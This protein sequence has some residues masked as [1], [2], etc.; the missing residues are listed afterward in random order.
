MQLLSPETIDLIF[1]EQAYGVDLV[2]GLPVRFGMGYALPSEAAP[3]LPDGRIAYWGGW[4]GSSIIVDTDRNMTIAY[5][6][7]RMADGLLGDDRGLNL[8]NAAYDAVGR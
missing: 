2:L 3:Q 5:M 4:G 1:D 7:N 8:H 6:M